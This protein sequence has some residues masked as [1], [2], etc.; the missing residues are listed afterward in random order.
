MILGDVEIII[1][2][3]KRT[4]GEGGRALFPLRPLIINFLHRLRKNDRIDPRQI[5]CVFRL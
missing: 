1:Y 2:L 4:E 3:E 5:S